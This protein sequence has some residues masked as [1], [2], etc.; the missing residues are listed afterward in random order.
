MKQEFK[1]EKSKGGKETTTATTIDW[2][3]RGKSNESERRRVR[4]DEKMTR[5]PE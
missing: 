3:L 2:T 1:R 4:E 5:F